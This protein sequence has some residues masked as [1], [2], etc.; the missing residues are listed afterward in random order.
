MVVP[1]CSHLVRYAQPELQRYVV[2]ILFMVPIYGI[3]SWLGLR[4][5]TL[6][7]YFETCREWCVWAVSGRACRRLSGFPLTPRGAVA[8][9]QLRGACRLLLLQ[10]DGEVAG[11]D[12]AGASVLAGAW[13]S[14]P[15]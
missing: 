11:P 1:V 2:R 15:F 9:V 4:F 3:E 13:S 12:G 5:R 14:L 8:D 10:A 6:A 7:P